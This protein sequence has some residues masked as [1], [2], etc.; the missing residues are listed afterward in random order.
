MM[1]VKH[2]AACLALVSGFVVPAMAQDDGVTAQVAAGDPE[3]WRAA[4]PENILIFDTTAGEVVIEMFP[5]VA[6]AHAE[7]FR[8]IVRSG[9]YDGTSFHRVISG[10]M[11]Q[12]GDIFAL[13]GRESGLPD[14]AGEF[15]F[16]RDP[17]AMP[18]DALGEPD[19]ARDGY[20]LGFPIRTQASWISEMSS[21]GLVES[22]IPHCPSVVSTART[23]DPDSANSQFFLMRGRAE[24]L[25]RAYTAW[26][27]VVSGQDAVFDIK[28]GEPPAAPDVLRRAI[29]AADLPD[30]ER[31]MVYVMR[32]DGPAAQTM[33]AE[34]AVSL[35]EARKAFD[36]LDFAEKQDATEPSVC[37]FDPIPAI[38]EFPDLS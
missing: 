7:Q 10:F 31:P 8:A 13:K 33:L 4:D 9:D 2:W 26:G 25:D 35:A 15:T 14:I 22:Y 16:R 19:I 11:A 37:D 28:V 20:H 36:E 17:A 23:S 5:D 34:R 18:F 21:D 30:A 29:V 1:R 32:T 6:P 27:R 38:V 12:G 24:H 3:N